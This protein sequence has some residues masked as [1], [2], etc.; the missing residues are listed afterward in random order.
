MRTFAVFAVAA[1]LLCVVRP[2]LCRQDT[3]SSARVSEFADWYVNVCGVGTLSSHHRAPCFRLYGN[4]VKTTGFTIEKN[5]NGPGYRAVAAVPLSKGSEIAHIP[6]GIALRLDSPHT[7][8]V[9]KFPATMKAW[10]EKF[11]SASEIE[12]QLLSS[13]ALAGLA[14][15]ERFYKPSSFWAPMWGVF[16]LTF[17][18]LP[19][20]GVFNQEYVA[21]RGHRRIVEL[22]LPGR[23]SSE[24]TLLNAIPELATASASVRQALELTLTALEADLV[25]PHPEVFG[26]ITAQTVG[27]LR[28]R[29]EWYVALERTSLSMLT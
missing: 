19:T 13:Q 16:P 17:E 20:S 14:F 3:D 15:Y 8:F 10:R 4:G 28:A 5:D 26:P 27:V 24:R 2:A 18:N 21:W 11:A 29:L 7:D 1:L 22:T 23:L 25:R 6:R 12:R 9:A